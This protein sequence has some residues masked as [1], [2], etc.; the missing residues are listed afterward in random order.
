P[1]QP[2]AA[3]APEVAAVVDPVEQEAEEVIESNQSTIEEEIDEPVAVTETIG[4]EEI[5]EPVAIEPILEAID[6]EIEDIDEPE[7]ED[8][9]E[10]IISQPMET[11]PPE[12]ESVAQEPLAEV[13]STTIEQPSETDQLELPSDEYE[14]AT[15]VQSEVMIEQELVSEQVEET[16][17]E[18]ESEP[19]IPGDRVIEEPEASES[20][21][22]S[23]DED[24]AEPTIL[25][26]I[27]E[28]EITQAHNLQNIV[29][30]SIAEEPITTSE[31]IAEPTILQ[32]IDEPEELQ[33]EVT[34]VGVNLN[35]YLPPELVPIE[36]APVDSTIAASDQ[37][38]E[39]DVPT[40]P[41]IL[42]QKQ[43][44]LLAHESQKA[45]LIE[46]I[47][48]HQ[49]ILSNCRLMAPSSL[50]QAL[51]EQTG[52]EIEQSLPNLNAGGYQKVSA[53]V[54]SG[55][56]LAVIF[57]RDFI[58]PQ[59]SQANDEALSR[60]CNVNSVIFAANT[61]TA[62]AIGSYLQQLMNSAHSKQLVE[63]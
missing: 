5:D 11:I 49:S 33:E 24:I 25:Q 63:V 2:K 12:E 58:T 59:P 26:M 13:T 30:E 4:E 36:I 9:P 18:S 1:D 48:R 34:A 52:I 10:L 27:D 22:T 54:V 44:A 37:D 3:I 45:A 39:A 19:T 42:Q 62:E 53:A 57:L 21:A 23:E 17:S 16:E 20:I 32:M 29:S 38:N 50:S 56:L 35:S 40:I 41:E 15:V 31:D 46:F 60:A 47:D 43:I 7:I 61:A 28:P 6:E 55:E 8:A 51:H 14:E